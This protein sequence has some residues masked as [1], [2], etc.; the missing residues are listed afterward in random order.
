MIVRDLIDELKQHNQLATVIIDTWPNNEPD[1]HELE[2][3]VSI[4]GQVVLT[5]GL[6]DERPNPARN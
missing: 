5:I 2:S 6:G 3:V 1:P 4:P